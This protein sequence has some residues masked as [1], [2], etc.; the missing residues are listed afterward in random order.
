[1]KISYDQVDIRIA[2]LRE[3]GHEVYWRGYSL[4]LHQPHDAAKRSNKGCIHNGKWGY[5]TVFEI[6]EKGYYDFEI[7]DVRSHFR[8]NR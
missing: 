6:D 2:Q 8:G 3:E 5:E 4:C 7:P 1:M